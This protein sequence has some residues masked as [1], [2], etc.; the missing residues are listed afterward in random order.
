M[1]ALCPPWT[2]DRLVC[3]RCTSLEEYDYY[4]CVRG[5]RHHR[6]C[7]LL[8][9]SLLSCP[10]PIS[11]PRAPNLPL[12]VCPTLASMAAFQLARSGFSPPAL[13][14][15]SGLLG[16][17]RILCR[18][19]EDNGGEPDGSG[20]EEPPESLFM[21]ELRRR[22]MT[23]TSLLEDSERGARG[24][25]QREMEAKED[26]G[27]GGGGRRERGSRNGVASVELEKGMTRPKELFMSVNSEGLEL[28]L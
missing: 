3:T 21:K 15:P 8:A 2:V 13:R 16:P 28:S 1:A 10:S 23:P 14:W 6:R 20:W 11:N 5:H 9:S 12:F 4:C 7:P 22:G 17:V 24:R 18:L 25:G 19:P 27:N 26:S